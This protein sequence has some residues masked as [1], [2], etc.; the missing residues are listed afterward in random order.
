MDGSVGFCA[1]D[2][3]VLTYSYGGDAAKWLFRPIHRLDRKWRPQV[4]GHVKYSFANGQVVEI[5]VP[6]N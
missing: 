3:T 2:V 1:V 6:P 5:R 4:W